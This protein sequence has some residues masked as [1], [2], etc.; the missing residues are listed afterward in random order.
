[1]SPDMAEMLVTFF[2]CR[3]L[4]SYLC[5]F[6]NFMGNDWPIP[7]VYIVSTNCKC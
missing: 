6:R 1:M 2:Y 5:S 7:Y 4:S 3:Y